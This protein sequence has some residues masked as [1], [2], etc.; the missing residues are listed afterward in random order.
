MYKLTQPLHHEQNVTNLVFKQSLTALNLK[1]SLS[2]TGCHTKVKELS[3]SYL[4][5]AGG[6]TVKCIPFPSVLALCELQTASSR[7]WTLVTQG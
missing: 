1:L 6:K 3:L 7:V 2:E 4:S 5:I